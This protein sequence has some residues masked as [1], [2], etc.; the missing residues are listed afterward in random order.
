MYSLLL[1]FSEPISDIPSS[2]SLVLSV[3]AT[4]FDLITLLLVSTYV[5]CSLLFVTISVI[6]G[7]FLHSYLSSTILLLFVL[8][9]KLVVSTISTVSF[10]VS[11]SFRF[12]K[13][14][15]FWRESDLSVYLTR[16]IPRFLFPSNFLPFSLSSF[17]SFP[18]LFRIIWVRS[19]CPESGR[20][21]SFSRHFLMNRPLS[22]FSRFPSFSS[23][24]KRPRSFPLFPIPSFFPSSFFS[25]FPPFSVISRYSPF[26]N[27]DSFGRSFP[28]NFS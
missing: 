7:Y 18:S 22:S 9:A 6:I 13:I 14:T 24:L 16:R 12:P 26:T 19:P 25:F 2:S 1:P 4:I 5:D 27:R 3:F 15:P 8:G 11:F 23:S 20:I 17:F 21:R 28:S 10:L